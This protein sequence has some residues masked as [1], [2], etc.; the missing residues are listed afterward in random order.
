MITLNKQ[1]V[2]FGSFPNGEL[3]LNTNDLKTRSYNAIDWMFESNDEIL[4]L[5]ILK[6]TLDSFVL[7]SF[8]N[9]CYM[10]YSRMDRQNSIYSFT[11][12]TVTKLINNMRFEYVNIREP[13]SDVTP[14]M[15]ERSFIINWC[16]CALPNV[17]EETGCTSIFYPDHGAVK[18]Y[19][20]DMPYAVGVKER[21]FE[22]GDITSFELSGAVNE[23]V[24]I[25]DDICSK[26]GTFYH[27]TKLLKDEG[28]KEVYLLVA[29]CENTVIQG[30]VLKIIDGI[31]TS[32]DN[33]H[34]FEHKLITLI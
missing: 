16:M 3:Y 28:A 33:I 30:E 6:D 4:K 22:T 10:P 25:V 9:I 14:A 1:E 7:K 19:S 18:R 8:L 11:L 15:I 13:H 2:I 29:Y 26:G 32:A 5:A 12:Q 24:L 34:L 23:K 27:S 20:C 21:D 31:Y 17:L